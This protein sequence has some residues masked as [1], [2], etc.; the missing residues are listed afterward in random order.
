[1]IASEIRQ[2]EAKLEQETAFGA[3]Q[4]LL[5]R[6]WKLRKKQSAEQAEAKPAREKARPADSPPS[7]SGGTQ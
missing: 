7:A 5:K 3:R 4:P 6:L 1:M 2:L